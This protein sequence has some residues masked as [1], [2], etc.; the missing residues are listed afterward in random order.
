M[1]LNL[2]A[3]ATFDGYS[4]GDR[5]SDPATVAK[6]LAGPHANHVVK[7]TTTDA[8]ASPTPAPT[9]AEAIAAGVADGVAAAEKTL[10]GGN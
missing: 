7:V 8:T 3:R 5:I 4:P 10:H 1:A 2:F 6:I 9:L